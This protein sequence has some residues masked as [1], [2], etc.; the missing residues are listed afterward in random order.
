M[1][2][3]E[4]ARKVKDYKYDQ[5]YIQFGF[6]ELPNKPQPVVC[7]EVLSAESMET[8]RINNYLET[9]HFALKE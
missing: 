2:A 5:I 1:T 8:S 4:C 7:S 6:T 3:R 9:K